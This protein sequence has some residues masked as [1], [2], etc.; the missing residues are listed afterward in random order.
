MAW[1]VARWSSASTTTPAGRAGRS[2]RTR[3]A[4]CRAACRRSTT[5]FACGPPTILSAAVH[6]GFD[7]LYL[8][9]DTVFMRNPLPPILAAAE[10]VEVLVSRDFGSTCLNT[11]VIFFKAHA[12]TATL[13]STLLVWLWHHPY[14]FSQKAFSAFLRVENVSNLLGGGL[15]VQ[16]DLRWAALD[17]HN[18][19]VTS[20]VYNA[21]VEG[22]TGDMD[23]IVVF[24]FLDGTGGVDITRAVAGEYINLY[25]L[26]YANPEL[27]LADTKVPLW[28]Q[29]PRVEAS[30]LRSRRPSPPSSLYPCMLYP[31][32][33]D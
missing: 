30:L 3:P 19:F 7:A 11:G 23:D 8:D 26:F 27:D 13:L 4:A 33:G 6:L 5:R 17:P 12:D 15:P 1:R 31:D 22:W 2:T 25:D 14:E 10:E 21:D 28:K 20:T 29:D 32:Q 24:H 18:Q 16:A 9:F